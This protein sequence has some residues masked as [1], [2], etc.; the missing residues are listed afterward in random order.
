MQEIKTVYKFWYEYYQILPKNHRHTLGQK[1]DNLFTDIIEAVAIATFLSQEE[2]APY[3]RL[4]IRKINTLNVFLLILWENK[5]LED[6]KFIWLSERTNEIGKEL[7][8][9][10]GRTLKQ[11]SLAKAREK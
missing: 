3:I 10:L 1:V 9:W 4:A 11:N 6:K 8:G 7:G 5:S 2:K